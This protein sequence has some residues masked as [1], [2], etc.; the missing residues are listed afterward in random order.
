MKEWRYKKV[1]YTYQSIL[2]IQ[3]FKCLITP[4]SWGASVVYLVVY[5]LIHITDV[6]IRAQTCD[7]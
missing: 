7:M 5:T 6:N 4:Q 3:D 2:E 1:K